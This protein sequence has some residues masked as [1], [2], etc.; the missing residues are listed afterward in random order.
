MLRM[1]DESST[2]TPI[3]SVYQAS[4]FICAI[5]ASAFG[6]RGAPNAGPKP[7][8]SLKGRPR[9]AASRKSFQPSAISFQLLTVVCVAIALGTESVVK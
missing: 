9:S 2:I 3:S 4:Y 8:G 6:E 5:V 7:G 1:R